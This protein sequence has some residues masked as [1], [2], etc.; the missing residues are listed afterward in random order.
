M[1]IIHTQLE[2]RAVLLF[3]YNNHINK[4]PNAG[5]FLCQCRERYQLS[6]KYYVTYLVCFNVN[7]VSAPDKYPKSYC[8][9]DSL[10]PG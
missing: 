9:K 2:K 5:V 8:N 4:C 10:E 6:Y 1:P 7:I 3:T